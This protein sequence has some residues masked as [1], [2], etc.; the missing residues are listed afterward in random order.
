MTNGGYGMLKPSRMTVVIET[1]EITTG[2]ADWKG[3]HLCDYAACTGTNWI[4]PFSDLA[5][6]ENRYIPS[7]HMP[8]LYAVRDAAKDLGCDLEFV[9]VSQLSFMQRMKERLVGNPIP[10]MIVGDRIL[11]G[12]SSKDEIIE[13]YNEVV[14]LRMEKDDKVSSLADSKISSSSSFV[15]DETVLDID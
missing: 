14:G 6:V 7:E 11:A 3:L 9:D 1:F 10:R 12:V 4:I 2:A 8:L 15:Q 5:G 13:F